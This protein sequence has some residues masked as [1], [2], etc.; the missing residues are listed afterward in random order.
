MRPARPARHGIER[1]LTDV[2]SLAPSPT[3]PTAA[4]APDRP[5]PESRD[6]RGIRW[7]WILGTGAVLLA[8][9]VQQLRDPDVWWHLALGNLIR[10]HGIPAHE[11]FTFL[12]A[13]NPW[14]GQ[15][16]G[17][18]VLLSLMMQA[19]TWL[20]MVVMGVVGAAAF[21]VAARTLPRSVR[22]PGS[23]LAASMLLSGLVA[24]SILGVRGQVVTVLGSAITLWVL[25][26]WREGS[27][28]VVWVLPPLLLVWAN[29]HAGFVTGIALCVLVALSVVAWRAVQPGAVPHARL[30]PLMLA[31]VV[32]VVATLVNPA[33]VHIYP[34][35]ASTFANPTLTQGI[36]EW[37]SPNFH[38][39][40]LR[41]F[42][43]EAM[44]LVILWALS[45]R[46]DPVDVVLGIAA[47]AIT[48][49]AQR[50]LPIFA[51]IAV[52]QIARYGW[53]AWTSWRRPRVWRLPA[54]P[55]FV[56][57]TVI[58]VAVAVGSIA[59]MASAKST[60]RSEA[61]RFPEA[62]ATYVGTHLAGQRIYSLYEW[63]GYLA[64]RFP[65]Q[66]VVHIYGESAVF[67]AARLERYLDIHLVRPDWQDVLSADGMT[68]AIVPADSQEATAFLEIGWTTTCHDAAS[69]AV[70]MQAPPGGVL[71]RGPSAPPS[72]PASAPSC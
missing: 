13:P 11:P 63:G 47:L 34:Y 62:A 58:G 59:P 50:N 38:D 8:F 51:V 37:M 30:Q 20:P 19:G 17:Y 12:G 67:G 29:L 28:R 32:A 23:F 3:P 61:T 53:T 16:W 65:T 46:P 45:R 64:W 7:A 4:G 42:E 72:D 40:W 26:R 21:V 1:E 25:M 14:V 69:N 48:L 52:P 39:W 9:T 70:V 54:G 31:V 55:A 10:A 71:G 60:A 35:I 44:L 5:Q 41:L 6:A 27:T 18:E 33:G 15:Q 43:G 36:T 68:V 49:Q 56:A 57:A 2:A 22:V 66:H 24:A